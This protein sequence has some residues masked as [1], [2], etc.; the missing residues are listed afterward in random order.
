M[1]TN[2][3]LTSSLRSTGPWLFVGDEP[4]ARFDFSPDG[5]KANRRKRAEEEDVG[6]DLFKEGGGRAS[7]ADAEVFRRNIETASVEVA[8]GS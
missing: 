1:S 2:A 3:T 6:S 7:F 5:R 8:Q 4:Y